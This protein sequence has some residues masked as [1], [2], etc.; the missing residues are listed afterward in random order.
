MPHQQNWFKSLPF[1]T[2]TSTTERLKQK[3][4]ASTIN[5]YHYVCR[6]CDQSLVD[7]K[8]GNCWSI[9]R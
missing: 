9:A 5:R 8:V 4:N 3:K 6:R 7:L 1:Q 2:E